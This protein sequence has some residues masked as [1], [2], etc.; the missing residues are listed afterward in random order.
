MTNQMEKA[1]VF[2]S[3]EA[4]G[5]TYEM[6]SWWAED[7]RGHVIA[8]PAGNKR[9]VQGELACTNRR[10]REGKISPRPLYTGY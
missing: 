2:F 7:E 10:V 3:S 6:S 5:T 4:G 1:T 9:T 8:G